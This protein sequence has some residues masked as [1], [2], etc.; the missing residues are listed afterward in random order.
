M[1]SLRPQSS[2][3]HSLWTCTRINTSTIKIATLHL[4]MH[5]QRIELYSKQSFICDLICSALLIHYGLPISLLVTLRIEA[6]LL[7]DC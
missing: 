6:F 7:K 4:N 5:V 1:P 2:A 3:W